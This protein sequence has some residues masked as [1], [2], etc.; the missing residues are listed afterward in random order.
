MVYRNKFITTKLHGQYRYYC[1]IAMPMK[2]R[3]AAKIR[4]SLTADDREFYRT[5]PKRLVPTTI[6]L[7]YEMIDGDPKAAMCYRG[8]RAIQETVKMPEQFLRHW[9]IQPIKKR[10]K[11]A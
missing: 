8:L 10:L 9:I 4:E 6:R 7:F 5:A 3:L 1:Q 11:A 2:P